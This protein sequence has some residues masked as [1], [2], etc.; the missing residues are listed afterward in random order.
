MKKKNNAFKGFQIFN[1]K[2]ENKDSIKMNFPT[3][4]IKSLLNR[5]R[6][7]NRMFSL[8]SSSCQK[9]DHNYHVRFYKII[10]NFKKITQ[11]KIKIILLYRL[12]LYN[13]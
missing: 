11:W 12:A 8:A 4:S 10:W 6:N 9:W 5:L 7:F 13:L 1:W 3:I 2:I